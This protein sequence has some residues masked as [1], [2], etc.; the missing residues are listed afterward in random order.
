MA[1]TL[2]QTIKFGFLLRNGSF[3]HSK[4]FFLICETRKLNVNKLCILIWRPGLLQNSTINQHIFGSKC[5]SEINFN[6][7][8]RELN[9]SE[10]LDGQ[11]KL[12]QNN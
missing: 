7:L 11:K 10:L 9:T 1:C 4:H 5:E 3:E 8:E 12:E 6:Y 2:K